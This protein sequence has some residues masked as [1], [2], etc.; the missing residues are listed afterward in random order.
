MHDLHNIQGIRWPDR[1]N[2]GPPTKGAQEGINKGELNAD[3]SGRARGL[4]VTQHRLEGGK[5]GEY[6]P[7]QL[8]MLSGIVAHPS[9]RPAL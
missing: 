7:T 6:S 9:Q 8:K 4:R 2:V 3:C 5:G 1:H